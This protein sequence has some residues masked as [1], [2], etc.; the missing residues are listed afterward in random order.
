MARQRTRRSGLR[1]GVDVRPGV[2]LVAKAPVAHQV[3][4]RLGAEVGYQV[5]ADLA[6]AALLDTL[7]ACEG[8]FPPDRRVVALCGD[9][10]RSARSL[11][12]TRRLLG[13][14]VIPQRGDGF[15]RRLVSAHGDAATQ[16]EAPVVQIGMDTPQLTSAHL[17]AVSAELTG[18]AYDAVLGPAADG[19]W[20]SLGLTEPRWAA[21]LVGVAMS[22]PRTGEAT[23]EML[24]A[25]GARVARTATLRDVDTVDDAQAVSV[26]APHT[27]FAEAWRSLAIGLHP[28]AELFDAALAGAPCVLH[29]MPGGPMELPVARWRAACNEADTALLGRC[30]GPTLDVGCGPGRM[31]H[32]L[33]VRGV[34]AL[35]IDVAPRAVRQTRDRGAQ[36][37]RRNVFDALPAEGR[38]ETVLLAD[39]NVGIGGRPVQ[40]LRRV[41]ELLSPGGR[42]VVEVAAPGSGASTH[43]VQIEVGGRLSLPFSWAVVGPE[44]LD[45]LAHSAALRMPRLADSGGRWFA[46]LSRAHGT[47]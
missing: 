2:L 7:D 40:L 1:S 8:T 44:A 15:G 4:T 25:L 9:L 33:A 34:A 37:L 31:T 17:L 5:A 3:K 32:G 11:E 16:L 6:A 22:T 29:G 38:W 21:G 30:S 42:A 41:G 20:W 28:A 45:L 26:E 13:W 24:T 43:Q 23:H 46:E 47:R 39:G 18:G 10:P 35:G 36:A 19:G 12:L 27:R 14:H